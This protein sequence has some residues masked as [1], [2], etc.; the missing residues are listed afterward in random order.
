MLTRSKRKRSLGLDPRKSRKKKKTKVFFSSEKKSQGGNS[1]DD[2]IDHLDLCDDQ[3]ESELDHTGDELNL[4]DSDDEFVLDDSKKS[5]V[6]KSEKLRRSTRLCQVRKSDIT[7]QESDDSDEDSDESDDTDESDEDSDESESESES[8]YNPENGGMDDA[9]ENLVDSMMEKSQGAVKKARARAKGTKWKT[10]LSEKEVKKYTPQ[11]EKILDKINVFPTVSRVLQTNM[12]FKEKCELVEKIYI[13]ENLYPNTFEHMSTK[14]DI[15]E[16]LRRYK[17]YKMSDSKCSKYEKIEESISDIGDA[18]PMKYRILDANIPKLNKGVLYRK[19]T[20]LSSLST[21]SSEHPKLTEWLSCA[22]SVPFQPHDSSAKVQD[23]R[24]IM[25]YLSAVQ[26]Q[27]DR[28]VYGLDQVKEQ[29]LFVLNSKL[30]NPE[31]KGSGLAVVGPPGTAKTSLVQSLANAIKLPMVQISLGGAKDSSFLDG[32]GYTYEGST[33]GAIVDALRKLNCNDG[34]IFFDEFDK[35][36]KTPYGAEISQLLLHI[37]DFTQNHN[38]YD[39]YLSTE[40]PIDLSNIWFIYSLNHIELL[41]RTLR[42][43]IPIIKVSGYSQ[44]EKKAIAIK[45][46]VP[47]TLEKLG[48][49]NEITFTDDAVDNLIK[50][51][52]KDAVKDKDGKSGVRQLKHNI[53][54]VVMKLNML[55]TVS[56]DPET[57]L[58]LSFRIE[59]FKLPFAVTKATINTLLK[60]DT[61]NAFYLSMYV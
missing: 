15:L 10:G 11:F 53:E 46:L 34:I 16:D 28:D 55:K 5:K 61:P 41:D 30:T 51:S 57:D 59:D 13:F 20:H 49:V 24:Q 9:I 18:I 39:K 48:L 50:K 58:K 6:K 25:K 4:S 8:D 35:I 29:L 27:L 19:Y 56:Q 47:R 3:S 17:N 52:E 37:T 40:F 54:I 32:H 7:V 44:K 36:S 45:H 23:A 33:P 2:D 12:P 38:F 42:D 31:S 26:K 43:R 14:T 60:E 22:L 1:S 21:S